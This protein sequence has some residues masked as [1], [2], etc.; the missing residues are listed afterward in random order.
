MSSAKQEKGLLN[1]ISVLDLADEKGSFCSK[2]LADFGALVTKVERPGGDPSR[3]MGPFGGKLSDPAQSLFF[4]YHNSNKLGITLDI[5]KE[6]G[7]RILGHLIGKVD[8]LVET[9]PPDYLGKLGLG[10][11]AL[12][13][14]NPRLILASLTGFGQTGPRRN[15]KSCDL[16]AA[17]MGGQMSVSG[18]PE[19][20]LKPFG[21]QSYYTASLYGAI[22]ILLAW[23]KGARTGKG[24]HL[25]ISLQEAAASTLGQVMARYLYE[26]IIP[27]RQERAR[28]DGTFYIL[29]CSDG[30]ILLSPF[31]HYG[32][33]RSLEE[34]CGLCPNRASPFRPHVLDFPLP[35]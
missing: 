20:P 24:A 13:K 28:G 29:P 30:H 10:F 19:V 18:L 4:A 2:L 5:E 16:V 3:K 35:G 9:F 33:E 8:V 34:F 22:G 21:E 25:D 31:H 27:E 11:K 23:R 26:K 12:T 17:A 7:R 6:E 32:A 14:I 15:Y 1:K